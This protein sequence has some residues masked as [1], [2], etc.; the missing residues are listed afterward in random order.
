MS[1]PDYHT[2]TVRC[3]HATGRAADYVNE[4]HRNGLPAIGIA[5]HLPLLHAKDLS[6]AMDLADLEDYV[7]EVQDLQRTFPGYVLLGIEADYR[8]DTL[9]D[10]RSLLCSYPF[11]YVIGSVHYLEGWGF[12]D[13]RYSNGFEERDIDHIYRDYFDL[14]GDAA[15]C[16]LFT[17]LGHLDLVKKFGHRPRNRLEAHVETL[18]ARIA[19]SGSI[20]EVNTAGLRRPAAEI[21]PSRDMLE[22]LKRRDIPITFG[23]DAHRP[24]EVGLGFGAALDLVR[25]CGYTQYA[26]IMPTAGSTGRIQLHSL[27]L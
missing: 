11:Q 27:P 10:L 14:V 12:D 21:Y 18:A 24:S 19:R 2:H 7:R 9:D 26:V 1:V 13:P 3:G 20:V 16:R 17:I 6:L 15:E 8:P 25:L 4:A 22:V 23:S 5:D